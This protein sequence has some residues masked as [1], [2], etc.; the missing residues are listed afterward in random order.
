MMAKAIKKKRSFG[1]ADVE[2][3]SLS[4]KD[5]C[6]KAGRI[7]SGLHSKH[8]KDWDKYGEERTRRLT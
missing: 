6:R 2:H 5:A 4:P 1:T 3:F 7:V 8:G